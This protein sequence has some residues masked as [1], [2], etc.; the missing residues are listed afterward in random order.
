MNDSKSGEKKVTTALMGK[1]SILRDLTNIKALMDK[2]KEQRSL[3]LYNLVNLKYQ[4]ALILC[5][6]LLF[7]SIKIWKEF[8]N[9]YCEE[10]EQTF[11][12]R[13]SKTK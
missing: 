13:T 11:F 7:T 3:A 9:E 4:N 5:R 6:Q 2:R 8:N 10:F 1:K 12:F